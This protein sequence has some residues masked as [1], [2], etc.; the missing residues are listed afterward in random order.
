MLVCELRIG[1][2]NKDY[3]DDD[4]DDDDDDVD[5]RGYCY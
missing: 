1:D 4:D 5:E 2:N 3:G